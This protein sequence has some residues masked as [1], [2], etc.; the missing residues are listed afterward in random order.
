MKKVI[1]LAACALVACAFLVVVKTTQVGTPIN[2]PVAHAPIAS[3]PAGATNG[4]ASSGRRPSP[5]HTAAGK[6]SFDGEL[7]SLRSM[8]GA[9]LRQVFERGLASPTLEDKY[10]AHL[11]F[12]LCHSTFRTLQHPHIP[13]VKG[14]V[15][16]HMD[17]GRQTLRERCVPFLSIRL[18]QLT[19]DGDRLREAIAAPESPFSQRLP[20]QA[21]AATLQRFRRMLREQFERFGPAALEWN[22]ANLAEWLIQK[23]LPPGQSHNTGDTP[24]AKR[25][26][27]AA[28]LAMCYAGF[29][30]SKTSGGLLVLCT[31][32]A[33][34][35]T[36]LR[37]ALLSKLDSPVEREKADQLARMIAQ[38]IASGRYSLLSL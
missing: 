22:A 35:G 9:Q 24:E 4:A 23:D 6:E 10:L 2:D 26:E 28:Y 12:D 17:E 32:S 13:D 36:D 27:T 15:V 7:R 11:A 8:N 37:E 38:A 1:G 33:V 29:D 30:C 34:C 25:V 18:E 21:D 20:E 31:Q 19:L 5:V 14:D 3:H 16:R